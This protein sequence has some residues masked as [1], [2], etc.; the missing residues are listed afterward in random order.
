[1]AIERGTLRGHHWTLLS[2][3]D[4]PKAWRGRGYLLIFSYREI[5]DVEIKVTLNCR[6]DFEY[7]IATD[8]EIEAIIPTGDYNVAYW[9]MTGWSKKHLEELHPIPKDIEGTYATYGGRKVDLKAWTIDRKG[10]RVCRKTV[11]RKDIPI[12]EAVDEAFAW[13][14]QKA[15]APTTNAMPATQTSPLVNYLLT[16]ASREALDRIAKTFNEWSTDEA[17]LNN[18][19]SLLLTGAHFSGRD[20]LEV[21]FSKPKTADTVLVK[22]KAV[23]ALISTAV[24]TLNVETIAK[25]PDGAIAGMKGA[26]L[27]SIIDEAWATGLIIQTAKRKKGKA[28]L[29]GDETEVL[30]MTA[31]QAQEDLVIPEPVADIDHTGKYRHVMTSLMA[32]NAIFREDMVHLLEASND[33]QRCVLACA[34]ATMR[35][36]TDYVSDCGLNGWN[37]K[38]EGTI[39][40]IETAPL[41]YKTDEIQKRLG[42]TTKNRS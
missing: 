7:R 13:A 31:R 32:K 5:T 11:M 22:I 20:I 10:L 19:R 18:N 14:R 25:L 42:L 3:D 36:G 4:R 23:S 38:L 33:E 37:I 39:F 28:I 21:T 34:M 2:G 29:T 41:I 35:P 16:T 6:T 24:T 8:E 17:A 15:P 1:M 9:N 27:D 40:S 30:S 26:R 12:H